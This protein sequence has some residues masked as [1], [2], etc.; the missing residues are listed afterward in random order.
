ML[1]PWQNKLCKY[2][3]R[4]IILYYLGHTNIIT[5]ILIER[6]RRVRVRRK[7]CDDRKWDW[8]ERDLAMQCCWL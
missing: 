6:G 5:R 7:R 3:S 2:G 1:F 8:R 4:L